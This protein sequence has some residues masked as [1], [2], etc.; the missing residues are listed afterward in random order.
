MGVVFCLPSPS[1]RNKV[2]HP[3]RAGPPNKRLRATHG[4][5]GKT[6]TQRGRG[7]RALPAMPRH[8]VHRRD[9][10]ETKPEKENNQTQGAN[11]TENK[12]HTS[13][14]PQPNTAKV[15]QNISIRTESQ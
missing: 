1:H 3:R 13:V 8:G 10:N 15:G 14:E 4:S 5:P 9:A 2:H 12:Q 7:P 11:H 6:I